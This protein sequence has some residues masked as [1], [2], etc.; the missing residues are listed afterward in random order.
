MPY[1]DPEVARARRRVYYEAHREEDNASSRAWAESHRAEKCAYNRAWGAAHREER[2][3]YNR[4]YR[5]AHQTEGQA[6][7][8]AWRKSHREELLAYYARYREKVLAA[9]G[10]YQKAHLQE[11]A[12]KSRR[13]R[14]LERSATVGPIDLGAIKVRDRMRC[15]ICGKRVNE[16]LK[17][18][19]PDSLSFDHSHPLGLGGPHTQENQRVVHLCCNVKRGIGRLPVQMVLC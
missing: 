1:K 19:H 9:V 5:E 16:K 13:R 14:A 4:A 2:L 11:H 10:A 18:P 12:E 7:N 8:R 17:H 6:A 3:V 15:C